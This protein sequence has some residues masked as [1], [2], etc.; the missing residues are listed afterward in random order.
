MRPAVPV[1]GEE[2]GGPDGA[3]GGELAARAAAAAVPVEVPGDPKSRE[4][5]GV[6]VDLHAG[7]DDDHDA[8]VVGVDREV[9]PAGGGVA[10]AGVLDDDP[11]EAA[12]G[13]VGL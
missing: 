3:V 2:M 8:V 4:G 13:L 10:G 1:L 6:P 5:G 7:G 9:A 12:V 11:D